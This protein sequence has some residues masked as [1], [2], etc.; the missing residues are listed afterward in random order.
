[1][2]QNSHQPILLPVFDRIIEVVVWREG[3]DANFPKYASVFFKKRVI[4]QICPDCLVNKM[5]IQLGGVINGAE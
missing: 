4:G 5:M 2:F 1:M 3:D